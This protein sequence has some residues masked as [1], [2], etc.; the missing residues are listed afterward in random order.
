MTGV[1][2]FMKFSPAGFV[3]RWLIDILIKLYNLPHTISKKHDD[4]HW[5][6]DWWRQTQKHLKVYLTFTCSYIQKIGSFSAIRHLPKTGIMIP[7]VMSFICFKNKHV[8]PGVAR[9]P[10]LYLRYEDQWYYL[11]GGL[12]HRLCPLIGLQYVYNTIKIILEVLENENVFLFS[13]SMFI[14]Y[15]QKTTVYAGKISFPFNFSTILLHRQ[16]ANWRLVD[17]Q[18]IKLL[19]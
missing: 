10:F 5:F 14:K 15:I 17:N 11:N 6:Q 4:Y 12:I 7:C 19:C 8:L 3:D 18:N 1:M 16:R 13:F 2:Y 9:V